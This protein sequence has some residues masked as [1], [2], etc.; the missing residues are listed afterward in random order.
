VGWFRRLADVPGLSYEGS[1]TVDRTKLPGHDLEPE[2][3]EYRFEGELRRR[4]QWP[5]PEGG[6]TSASPVH[7][8]V[9][10]SVDQATTLETLRRLEET[11]ELPGELSDYHYAIQNVCETIYKRRREDLSLLE[12]VERLCWL[13][14]ELFEA[15]PK[16]VEYEPGQFP[17]VFAYK[18]LVVLYE[19]EGYF[20]E[21]LEVAERGL[22]MGQEHISAVAERLR[23]ILKELEAEDVGR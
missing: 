16:M 15:Y 19:G 7:Q 5:T 22:K 18:R 6:S 13:D 21:A 1:R 9:F 3:R 20:R 11:L 12:E 2:V 17:H 10:R 23:L 14:I 8:R 4:L